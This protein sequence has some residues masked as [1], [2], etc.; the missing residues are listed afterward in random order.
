M[1]RDKT[2]AVYMTKVKF[3]GFSFYQKKK[4]GG[5]QDT[6]EI[7]TETESEDKGKNAKSVLVKIDQWMRRRIRMWYWKQ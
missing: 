6:S 2:Q 4:K 5:G 7:P 3:P 1:N